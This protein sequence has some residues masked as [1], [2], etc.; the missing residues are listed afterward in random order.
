MKIAFIEKHYFYAIENGINML[1]KELKVIGISNSNTQTGAFA[2]ILGETENDMRIPIIIGAYEAQAIALHLENLSP[3]RPLTHDLFAN[4]FLSFQIILHEVFI[5]KFEEGIFYSI[6]YCEKDGKM[7]EIDSRTSDAIALAVRL[8]APIFCDEEIIKKTAISFE[9]PPFSDENIEDD[10]NF[11]IEDDEDDK[12][13]TLSELEAML[14][15]AV[16]NEDFEEA[17]HLRDLI[18]KHKEKK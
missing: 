11:D 10:E 17:S 9:N 5:N 1:K 18:N 12:V 3:S 8:N 13:Q 16:E 6:L 15:E 7:I 4:I 14:D 2:L